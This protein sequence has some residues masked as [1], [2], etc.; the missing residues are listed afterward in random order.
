MSEQD[1]ELLQI[2]I[3]EIG[4]ERWSRC[5]SHRH[6]TYWPRPSFYPGF[7]SDRRVMLHCKNLTHL[8]PTLAPQAKKLRA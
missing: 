1:A 6:R 4:Q 5:R 3:R 8:H 2:L 7:A